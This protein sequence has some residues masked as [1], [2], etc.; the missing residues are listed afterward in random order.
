MLKAK[1]TLQVL[2]I[3]C[4]EITKIMCTSPHLQQLHNQEFYQ[5]LHLRIK[6]IDE[7]TIKNIS[8]L[9][10]LDMLYVKLIIIII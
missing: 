8:S 7:H 2:M 10:G 3:D 6:D 9:R 1:I 5:Q 4:W